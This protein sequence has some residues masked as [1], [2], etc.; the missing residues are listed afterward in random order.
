VRAESDGPDRGS[1]F[2]LGLPLAPAPER[3]EEAPGA[4][5]RAKAL[6]VL[7]IEDNVDGAESLAAVLELHGH[8]AHIATDGLLG[9]RRARELRPDVILCDIDLPGMSG[10][11]IAR[12]LRGE[13]EMA[14]TRLVA[15]SG[16]AGP[17]DRQRAF[18]AGFNAHLAK[19]ISVEELTALLRG[20][21]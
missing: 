13:G 15:L 17:T 2:V 16:F 20:R 1:R 19:P 12:R 21:A 4:A 11:E 7:V 10:Y 3:R 14:A 8:R 9:L 6:E 5:D 18:D